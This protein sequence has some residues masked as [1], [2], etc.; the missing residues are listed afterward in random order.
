M[1][2]SNQQF[3]VQAL[4]G[5]DQPTS[6]VKLPSDT[7]LTSSPEA[8]YLKLAADEQSCTHVSSGEVLLFCVAGE[9]RVTVDGQQH[10]L[11]ANQMLYLGTGLPYRIKALTESALLTTVLFAEHV[12]VAQAESLRDRNSEVDEALEETFPASD[13]PS[14]NATSIS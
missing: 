1:T 10:P 5:I 11:Q 4:P 9:L 7:K 8:N 12:T 3:D 14:Y 6:L 13:P 2:A